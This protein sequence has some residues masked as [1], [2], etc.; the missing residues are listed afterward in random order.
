MWIRPAYRLYRAEYML[1]QQGCD[2]LADLYAEAA[3][4]LT[5]QVALVG[6]GGL[7]GWR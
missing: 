5:Q 6:V 1:R 3:D 2:A 7:S 4:E